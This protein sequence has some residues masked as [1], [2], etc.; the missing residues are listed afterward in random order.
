MCT[1]RLRISQDSMTWEGSVSS[2]EPFQFS[3]EHGASSLPLSTLFEHCRIHQLFPIPYSIMKF[4]NSYS[5]A[6]LLRF[7][8]ERNKKHIIRETCYM[9]I[10]R[11]QIMYHINTRST[12]RRIKTIAPIFNVQLSYSAAIIKS[13]IQ[14]AICSWVIQFSDYEAHTSNPNVKYCARSRIYHSEPVLLSHQPWTHL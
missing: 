5:R 10:S 11:N 13:K 7:W 1:Q 4:E 6:F 8:G 9:S 3:V 14:C 2:V 12:R